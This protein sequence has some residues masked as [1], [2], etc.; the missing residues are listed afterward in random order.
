MTKHFIGQFRNERELALLYK[1]LSK[2]GKNHMYTLTDFSE[3]KKMNKINQNCLRLAINVY[4]RIPI[5]NRFC[6]Y[7]DYT[8]IK[9]TLMKGGHNY[10]IVKLNEPIK[11]NKYLLKR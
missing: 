3:I 7:E 9:D 2:I 10:E 5:N 4:N 6:L 1:E 8:R 11:L